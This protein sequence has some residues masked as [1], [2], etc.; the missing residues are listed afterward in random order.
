MLSKSWGPAAL[1]TPGGTPTRAGPGAPQRV[2]PP[3]ASGY[4][5]LQ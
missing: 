3:H 2:S 5:C 1:N 4:F